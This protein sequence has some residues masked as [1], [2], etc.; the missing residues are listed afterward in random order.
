[1]SSRK[2]STQFERKW[3]LIDA[4]EQ[5]L[6]RL[7]SQIAQLLQGKNKPNF[8]SYLDMGDCV[9]VV[10]AEKVKVTGRKEKQKKY[11]R[12]TGYPGGL[13]EETLEKLRERKPTE[14][15]R[16]AVWGMMPKGKLGKQMMKKLKIFG[17]EE[18][19]YAKLISNV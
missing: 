15:I 1:M 4:K 11:Y 3:H 2:A 13:R 8:V 14:I 6:G 16:R 18:H 19:P 9:V 7:A 17:G 12:H 10:N 5:V